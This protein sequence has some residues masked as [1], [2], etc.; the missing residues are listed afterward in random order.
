M[1]RFFK[2]EQFVYIFNFLLIFHYPSVSASQLRII[3]VYGI[4][5]N[6]MDKQN[7]KSKS[8]YIPLIRTIRKEDASY[9]DMNFEADYDYLM[10][11]VIIGDSCVGKSMLLKKYVDGNFSDDMYISTI[12]VDFNVKKLIIDNTDEIINNKLCNNSQKGKKKKKSSKNFKV[13][14]QVWDTAGQERFRSITQSYYKGTK[15]CIICFDSTRQGAP[16]SLFKVRDWLADVMRHTGENTFAYV[17]G[18]KIDLNDLVWNDLNRVDDLASEIASIEKFPGLNVKFMGWCSSKRDIYIKNILDINHILKDESRNTYHWSKD[19][20]VVSNANECKDHQDCQDISTIDDMFK[21]IIFDYLRQQ[22]DLTQHTVIRLY[23][24]DSDGD[25]DK[26]GS[27][28]C[29]IL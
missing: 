7:G 10:K 13:K 25:D 19:R 11:M 21:E 26:H 2:D 8:N 29:I 18:T 12:G 15:I 6:T 23:D 9:I 1:Y 27:G 4:I 5:R 16:G 3:E 20:P 17:I 28:C 24:Y 14:V 22:S